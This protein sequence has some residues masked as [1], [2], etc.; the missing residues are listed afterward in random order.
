MCDI[1]YIK[2]IHEASFEISSA[3]GSCSLQIKHIA[4]W[5]NYHGKYI[6]KYKVTEL[7]YN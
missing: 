1:S 7:K 2:I 4:N 6:I 3:D 5:K